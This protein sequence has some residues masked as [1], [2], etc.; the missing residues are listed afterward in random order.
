MSSSIN[1][2]G[3]WNPLFVANK[4]HLYN[5]T[6]S[7]IDANPQKEVRVI[8]LNLGTLS[9]LNGFNDFNKLDIDKI[10]EIVNWCLNQPIQLE[11]QQLT[12]LP[13]T[14]KK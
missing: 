2:N 11:I 7:L 3:L 12:L 1:Q 10:A 5:V 9:S 4:K 14:L 13:T 6:Q 8:N